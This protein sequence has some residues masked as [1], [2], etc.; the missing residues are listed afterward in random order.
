MIETITPTGARH[1]T[2]PGASPGRLR[3]RRQKKLAVILLVAVALLAAAIAAGLHFQE[4]LASGAGGGPKARADAA[5]AAAAAAIPELPP[6]DLF[7]PLSPEEAQK[8]NA[9]RPVEAPTVAAALPF[10]LRADEISRLRAVDCLTQAIYYEAASEGVDGGRAV[11]QVILNR[12]RHGGYPNSVCGVVYQGSQRVT[13]CQFTFTCDGSLARTPVAYLWARSRLIASEALAGRTFAPVGYSTHYHADYV[14]PYWAAS[15]DKVAVIGR[16]I[17]YNFR[18]SAGSRTAFRQ[19]YAGTEP[20]VQL[21]MAEV[22]S[23][24]LDTLENVTAPSDLPAE[25][26]VEE[27]RVEVLAPAPQVKAPDSSP[28]QA[29]LARGQLILGEAAPGT[30]PKPKASAEATCKNGPVQSVRAVESAV[31]RVGASKDGC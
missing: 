12:V 30:A 17:F 13:G 29:D 28:L 3:A 26:K 2:L 14:V 16:H 31:Q 5:A 24:S 18:G 1:L 6:P 8:L 15:L 20:S 11:A 25:I 23:D 27:D 9:E 10:K 4:S 22:I 21:P 19:G 7:R